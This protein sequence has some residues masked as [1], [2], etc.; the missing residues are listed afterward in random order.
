M[1]MAPARTVI[2]KDR[3]ITADSVSRQLPLRHPGAQRLADAGLL[4][5]ARHAYG[6]P[7]AIGRPSHRFHAL[8]YVLEGSMVCTTPI[9]SAIC[10][11]GE[12][13]IAPGHRPFLYRADRPWACLEFRLADLPRWAFLRRHSPHRRPGL[14]GAILHC[15]LEGALAE[16]RSSGA[17][18]ERALAAWSDLLLLH[19]ERELSALG[20]PGDDEQRQRLHALL[21]EIER[22]PGRAWSVALMAERMRLSPSQLHRVMRAREGLSPAAVLRQVRMR[23]AAWLLSS[24]DQP[25]KAL[26]R[27]LGY[28]TAF[29]FSKAFKRQRGLAPTGF[30]AANRPRPGS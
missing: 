12:C 10:R 24:G 14:H 25:M 16:A 21:A 18:A 1:A 19:L 4:L 6:A 17:E 13:W 30:R 2:S 9:G 11:P 15:C 22:D 27:R 29:S 8:L 23:K 5:A 3:I 28:E 7:F 26:A 20:Q